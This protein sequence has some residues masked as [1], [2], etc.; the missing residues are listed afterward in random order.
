MGKDPQKTMN[1]VLTVSAMN[2]NDLEERKKVKGGK[3]LSNQVTKRKS[4]SSN[5]F[6][7]YGHMC[8]NEM[9]LKVED[10]LL[11]KMMK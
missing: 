10:M 8:N 5:F 6:H 2:E 7:M 3:K 1:I 4:K 11:L 9:R